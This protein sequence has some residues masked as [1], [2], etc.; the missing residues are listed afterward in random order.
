M[1]KHFL[2]APG[3]VSTR[4]FVPAPETTT[5]PAIGLLHSQI[6]S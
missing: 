5:G 2:N 4:T 3:R 6:V 1:Y